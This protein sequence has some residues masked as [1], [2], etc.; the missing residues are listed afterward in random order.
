MFYVHHLEKV[1]AGTSLACTGGVPK[2]KAKIFGEVHFFQK[3][4]LSS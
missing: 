1:F 4:L 2:I 3:R